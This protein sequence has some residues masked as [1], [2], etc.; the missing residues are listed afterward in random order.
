MNCQD[1]S[2]SPALP[3]HVIKFIDDIYQAAPY[4]DLNE[5]IYWFYSTKAAVRTQVEHLVETEVKLEP[6]DPVGITE[7]KT[8]KGASYWDS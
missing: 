4:T 6:K 7:C 5:N 2:V 8:V 1:P 3:L